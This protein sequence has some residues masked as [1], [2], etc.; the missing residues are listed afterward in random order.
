MRALDILDEIDESYYCISG[1]DVRICAPH[2]LQEVLNRMLTHV[3]RDWTNTR[4][5]LQIDARLHR[6][7]WH[8]QGT[9]PDSKKIL[10][11]NYAIPQVAGAVVASVL[12]EIA[13]HRNVNVWRAAVVEYGGSALVLAGDDWES[14]ITLA[15]HLHT[16]GWRLLGG[17]YALVSCDTLSAVCFKKS[18]HANSSSVASFPLWYRRAV[19]ASPWYS[20]S[21]LLAFYAIDPTLVGDESPWGETAPIR[22]FLK[23]DG[24]TADRP[25]LASGAEF[26]LPGGLRRHDLMR[27]GI[28]V[29]MLVRSGFGETCDFLEP[30][31]ATLPS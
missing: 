4:E 12:A 14:C 13:H 15:V 6:D 2:R 3:A 24:H 29:A 19:E 26:T 27:G 23:V 11:H 8:I 31:F 21:D 9:A 18:L 1:V 10:G 7:A 17:D 22:A 20:C 5:P 28:E 25:S 30:W 16:R